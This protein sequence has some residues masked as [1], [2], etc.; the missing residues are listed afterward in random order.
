VPT[1]AILF[2]DFPRNVRN[3]G[4]LNRINH[5]GSRLG[6]EHAEDAGA[7]SDVEY[8]TARRHRFG[9]GT[10]EGFTSHGILQHRHLTRE[11]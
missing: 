4:L 6:R 11:S 7:G 8:R 2:D 3:L 9:N 5:S 10:L 1:Q